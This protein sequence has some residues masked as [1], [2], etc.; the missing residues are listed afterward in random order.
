MVCLNPR[1]SRLAAFARVSF[2]SGKK[3]MTVFVE[4]EGK[5]VYVRL[6]L[7]TFCV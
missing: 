2:R 3:A 6:E 7:T 1:C 4:R 5:M